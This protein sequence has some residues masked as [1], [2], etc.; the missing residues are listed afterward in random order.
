MLGNCG[1]ASN[2]YFNLE[3]PINEKIIYLNL[4][5]GG[6]T[7]QHSFHTTSIPTNEKVRVTVVIED[8]AVKCYVNGVLA[9]TRTTTNGGNGSKTMAALWQSVPKANL[10]NLMA[11][12]DDLR[13]TYRFTGT[14][15]D[16]AM[17]SD[18][19][20]AEEI[21]NSSI[22]QIGTEGYQDNLLV[23][24]DFQAAHKITAVNPFNKDL[25]GSGNHLTGTLNVTDSNVAPSN[26][27]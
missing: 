7:Y 1:G 10:S 11:I 2:D 21:A 8:A 6:T 17:W 13:K 20:T 18:V 25:S 9:Q 16:V 19:R 4:C 3:A 12:G 27:Q 23:A 14:I 22:T 5:L 24:Y 26:L 15:Y